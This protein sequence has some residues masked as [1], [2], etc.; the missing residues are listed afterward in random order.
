MAWKYHRLEA[1]TCYH[2]RFFSAAS[3]C[4]WCLQPFG[5]SATAAN[6]L[7][8][9]FVI[10]T[11]RE[12]T[13]F[14][15]WVYHQT[16]PFFDKRHQQHDILGTNERQKPIEWCIL[17]VS[18]LTSQFGSM[19]KCCYNCIETL[20]WWERALFTQARCQNL[21]P[22]HHPTDRH[23]VGIWIVYTRRR[24]VWFRQFPHILAYADC[25][26]MQTIMVT[27]LTGITHKHTMS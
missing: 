24:G 2:L 4:L 23:M 11:S 9:I 22:V 20:T 25:A 8:G 3:C 6:T 26:P 12:I 15:A 16:F 13:I 7:E 14:A 10:V 21:T 19:N 1:H 17:M 18:Q 27:S 5:H